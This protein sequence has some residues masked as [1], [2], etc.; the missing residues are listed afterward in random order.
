MSERRWTVHRVALTDSTNTTLK[1]M[2]ADGAPDG[3]VLIADEQSGGHGRMGRAFYSPCGGLYMSLLL[4][5]SSAVGTSPLWTVAAAVAA[6]EGCETLCGYPIGIKWVN[7]LYANGRKVC[8]ILAEAVTDPAS[9]DMCSVVGFGVNV[10]PPKG[11]FPADIAETAGAL[12]SNAPEGT[13]ERLAEAIL[14]RF[15]AHTKELDAR[16]FLEGYRARSIL[17]GRKVT[18]LENGKAHT[19]VVYGVD[20][21]GGLLVREEDRRRVLTAGEVTMHIENL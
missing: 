19:A 7:D 3:T 13:R 5:H 8:G 2:A 11:G 21:N 16:T 9:G 15:A 4:R 12:F 14:A 20:D 10:I 17:T 1:R 6:A 18:F